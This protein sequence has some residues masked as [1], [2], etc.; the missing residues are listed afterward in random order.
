SPMHL[1]R[2]Y[3]TQ[4]PALLHIFTDT[5]KRVLAKPVSLRERFFKYG[6]IQGDIRKQLTYPAIPPE[7]LP[8]LMKS[9]SSFILFR[10]RVEVLHAMSVFGTRP[11][12]IRMSGLPDCIAP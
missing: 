8:E 3:R 1:S 6:T 9:D 10:T 11:H 4:S 2:V 12:R 5:W 7:D